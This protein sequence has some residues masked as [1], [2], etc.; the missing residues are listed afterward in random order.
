M[1]IGS[2]ISP[3]ENNHQHDNSDIGCNRNFLVPAHLF[4]FLELICIGMLKGLMSEAFKGP[5]SNLK[6]S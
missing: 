2:Y 4:V 6:E 5:G 1:A 3:V